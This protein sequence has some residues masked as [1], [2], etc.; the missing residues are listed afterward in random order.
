MGN[1]TRL[2]GER[3]GR[4][5]RSGDKNWCS[6]GSE[7]S[8]QAA[9]T[10]PHSELTSHR[11]IL[12]LRGKI[13]AVNLTG[14]S[15]SPYCFYFVFCLSCSHCRHFWR[16]FYPPTISSPTLYI[17]VFLHHFPVYFMSLCY[18]LTKHSA[19]NLQ[20]D[21]WFLCGGFCLCAV[22]HY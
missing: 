4:E 20:I 7:Q 2:S 1:T 10:Y 5:W 22:H 6:S 8:H 14:Q 17:W 12:S 21:Y 16:R 9:N 3:K 11:H 13:A 18:F 19:G 15:L